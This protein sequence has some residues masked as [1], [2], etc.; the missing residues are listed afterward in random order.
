MISAALG[1]RAAERLDSRR[2]DRQN[3]ACRSPKRLPHDPQKARFPPAAHHG[4]CCRGG[5][6]GHCRQRHRIRSQHRQHSRAARPQRPQPA[7]A[8][9]A[10]AAGPADACGYHAAI[11][12]DRF[13]G[14]PVFDA[15][16]AAQP[17]DVR[18]ITTQGII[19]VQ[20]LT[21]KAPCT[22]FSFRFLASG[23][24]FNK[25]HCHRLTTQG[26]YVLQCGDPT[27]TGSGGP[28]YCVQRREPGRRHLPG[29]HGRHGQRRTEHQRQPVLLHL[30]GHHAGARTTPRSAP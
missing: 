13:K 29:R 27:G 25:T 4:R 14:I 17:F 5:R 20:M 8:G 24:Y 26:I 1:K 10:A 19:T 28:G 7:R 12:A 3:P 6:G 16:Q 18:F 22:T 30:E 9:A 23:G 15:A 2:R 11:P 21:G